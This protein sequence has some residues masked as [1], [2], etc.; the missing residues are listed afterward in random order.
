M[1]KNGAWAMKRATLSP[2][3]H[4]CHDI[5]KFTAAHAPHNTGTLVDCQMC[6]L[7]HGSAAKGH[8]KM[9]KTVACKQCH[10]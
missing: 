5:T 9:E 4:A 6:H 7:P 8:L 10:S 3:C 1:V 2:L